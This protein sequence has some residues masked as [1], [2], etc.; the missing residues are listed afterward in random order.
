MLF[1]TY[2]LYSNRLNKYYIGITED[3]VRRLGEHNRGK[4]NFTRKGNAW[5]LVYKEDFSSKAAAF[6]RELQIKKKKSRN[7]IENLIAMVSGHPLV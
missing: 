4:S 5:V 1:F 6:K 3:L 7:Y 2:I